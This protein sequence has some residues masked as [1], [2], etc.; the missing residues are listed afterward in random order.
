MG[1]WQLSRAVLLLGVIWQQAG[2]EGACRW[3]QVAKIPAPF[4]SGRF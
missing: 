1:S 4:C 3:V 2:G